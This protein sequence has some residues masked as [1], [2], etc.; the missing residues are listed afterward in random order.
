M[1][2]AAASQKKCYDTHCIIAGCHFVIAHEKDFNH[3]G[4]F[5]SSRIA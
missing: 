1:Q 4:K 5:G 2:R 3:F